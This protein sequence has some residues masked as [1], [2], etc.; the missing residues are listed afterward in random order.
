M[1]GPF[2]GEPRPYCH[3]K[4]LIHTIHCPTGPTKFDQLTTRFKYEDE[5][6][7]K[8]CGVIQSTPCPVRCK[9]C[10]EKQEYITK[11]LGISCPFSCGD[12]RG[13][14]KLYNHVKQCDYK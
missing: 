3:K 6:R 7:C 14:D 5:H 8:D 9:S 10:E 13:L 1:S 4:H 11:H 12:Y 2:I